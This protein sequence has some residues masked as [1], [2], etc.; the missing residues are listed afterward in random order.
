M[1]AAY[2]EYAIGKAGVLESQYAVASFWVAIERF[3]VP[4]VFR[5][6]GQVADGTLSLWFGPDLVSIKTL[7][8]WTIFSAV[9]TMIVSTTFLLTYDGGLLEPISHEHHIKVA[10]STLLAIVTVDFAGLIVHRWMFRHGTAVWRFFVF[11]PLALVT[12]YVAVTCCNIIFF[13]SWLA[14][15]WETFATYCQ[16]PVTMW[17][18]ASQIVLF[19]PAFLPAL[20]YVTCCVLVFVL[21][22]TKLASKPVLKWVVGALGAAPQGMLTIGAG[23]LTIVAALVATVNAAFIRN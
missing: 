4:N 7:V 13:F 10:L 19:M 20:L 14:V 23:T 16:W 12:T 22:L 9:A 11:V 8:R 18:N 6:I 3:Q 5:A 21:A 15:S 1:L 2:A 17:G